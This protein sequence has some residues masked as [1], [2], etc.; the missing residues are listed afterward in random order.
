MNKVAALWAVVAVLYLL[1]SATY[2]LAGHAFALTEEP[3]TLLH[4][5]ALV[6]NIVFMAYFEGYKGFQ[7]AF[8]PRF[9]ARVRYIKNHGSTLEM[10]LAPFFCFGFFGTTIKRQVVVVLVSLMIALMAFGTGFVPQPW[11]GIID[12]GVVVGLLWG[13]SSL[14]VFVFKALK[15]DVDPASPEL[16]QTQLIRLKRLA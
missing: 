2:R 3:L 15:E 9:A 5:L 10:L 11:R 12:A 14:L 16:S 13:V 7:L 1:L 6:G 4:W 8:S